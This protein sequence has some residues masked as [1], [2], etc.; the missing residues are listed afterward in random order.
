M[1]PRTDRA[2]ATKRGVTPDAIEQPKT[3]VFGCRGFNN[4][5]LRFAEIRTLSVTIGERKEG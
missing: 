3:A 1:P 5:V 4:S 2:T